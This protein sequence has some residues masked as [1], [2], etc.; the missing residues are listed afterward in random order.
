[1]TGGLATAQIVIV[2]RRQVVMDKRVGMDQL[3]RRRCGIHLLGRHAQGFAAGIGQYR[4]YPLAA[5]HDAVAHGGIQ[6]LELRQ[7]VLQLTVQMRF[8]AFLT[9]AEVVI[10]AGHGAGSW[11]GSVVNWPSC[12]SSRATF[13]SAWVR[14]CWHSRVSATPCSNAPRDSSRL[15]LPLSSRSTRLCR[16]SSDCSK[17]MALLVVAMGHTS[18]AMVEKR[19]NITRAGIGGQSESGVLPQRYRPPHR[20]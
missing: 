1:M 9:L 17:S 4:A 2:H 14:A 3:H 15:R 7:R 20:C 13:C 10:E 8:Y 11:K 19:L 16:A 12:S 18:V 6:A 5:A